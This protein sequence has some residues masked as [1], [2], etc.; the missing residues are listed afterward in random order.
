MALGYT[1]PI[2]NLSA[3]WRLQQCQQNGKHSHP[4]LWRRHVLP[5]NGR[6]YLIH[7]A[8]YSESKHILPLSVKST[9]LCNF[10]CPHTVIHHET[11]WISVTLLWK[12]AICIYILIWFFPC[13]VTASDGMRHH[14]MSDTWLHNA[15][16]VTIPIKGTTVMREHLQ[17][18]QVDA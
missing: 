4:L 14:A 7:I 6:Y 13:F 18:S 2:V 1:W 17:Y 11:G 8:W 16:S 9:A 5:D 15:Y 3:N 10:L 12:V